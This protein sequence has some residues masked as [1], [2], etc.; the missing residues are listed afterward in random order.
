MRTLEHL[1]PRQ[2]ERIARETL[3]I[4]AP[5]A[6]RLGMAKVKNELE[7]LALKYL[8]LRA[9]RA[10]AGDGGEAQA[11]RRVHQGDQT[12]LRSEL[13]K[14]GIVCDIYGRRKHLHSIYRKIKRQRIDVA[15]CTTTSPS[16]S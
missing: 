1:S 3:D 11:D 12:T 7:D 16:G 6:N 15:R 8:D 10:G 9:S 5:I 2:Q 14:G 13:D 4:Y